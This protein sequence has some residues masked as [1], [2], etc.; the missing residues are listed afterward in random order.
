MLSSAKGVG[1][2]G[3]ASS[4]LSIY[5]MLSSAKGVGGGGLASS[6]LSIYPMLSSAK[7]VGG[8]RPGLQ[9]SVHTQCCPQQRG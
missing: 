1:R 3:L 7:G 2:G 9:H 6:I 8:G 5:P 4:I